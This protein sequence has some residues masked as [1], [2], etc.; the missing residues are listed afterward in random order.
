[1]SWVSFGRLDHV[2]HRGA[3]LDG[4]LWFGEGEALQG[5]IRSE[6]P[7][8]HRGFEFLAQLRSIDRNVD[9]ALLLETEYDASL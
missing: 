1:M 2:H 4:E 3:D 8:N 7:S 6:S 5:S 9:D